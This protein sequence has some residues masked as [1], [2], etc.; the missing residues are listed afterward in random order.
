MRTAWQSPTAARAACLPRRGCSARV[1]LVPAS[2]DKK[3]KKDKGDSRGGDSVVAPSPAVKAAAEVAKSPAKPEAGNGDHPGGGSAGQHHQKFDPRKRCV[4]GPRCVVSHSTPNSLATTITCSLT[5]AVSPEIL[6]KVAERAQREYLYEH[7]LGQLQIELVK[8]QEHV[9]A[10]G[11]KVAVVFEGRDAAGKGGVI[12]R[13]SSA[14][15]PRI[16]RVVALP[17]PS[18]REKTQWYFQRYVPHLPAAGEIVLF[19]RSWYNRA[20]VEKVMGFCTD[21]QY[22]QFMRDVPMFEQSLVE[23]GTVL[24]KLWLEVSDDEQERRFQDRLRRSWKRWKLSP[25]DLFARSRWTEYARARDAMLERTDSDIAPWMCI[26]SDM[27]QLAQ[28]N[29]ISYILSKVDYEDVPMPPLS[30]PPRETDKGY[31]APPPTAWRWVPE[32]Y[33]AKHLHVDEALMLKA[34]SLQ[35]AQLADVTQ[36]ADISINPET[37]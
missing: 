31:T 14:M 15:S 4:G 12:S 23:S 8:L 22:E 18:D 27:K 37:P 17:A 10:K 9:K 16:C 19:D 34:A 33:T 2:K 32:V 30:L 7:T 5:V 6:V 29:C 13:L 11:L 35:V 36:L 3:E 20:G 24:I 25:M 28:L 26:N 21:T 1:L